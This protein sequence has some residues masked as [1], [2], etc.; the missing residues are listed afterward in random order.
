[1]LPNG[2]NQHQ[3]SKF[4]EF[5]NRWRPEDPLNVAGRVHW[6][7]KR[8]RWSQMCL[9][10]YSR[11]TGLTCNY[12]CWSVGALSETSRLLPRPVRRV[13]SGWPEY[14]R[15][16]TRSGATAAAEG[17]YKSRAVSSMST[18]STARLEMGAPTA[19]RHS[20]RVAGL[21]PGLPYH[22][23]TVC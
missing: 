19:R 7:P 17:I 16:R 13:S 4:N 20:H 8:G 2:D 3:R 22:P 5:F 12:S 10:G 21:A 14:R 1:M 23:A 9:L 15:E 18:R 11:T 6:A